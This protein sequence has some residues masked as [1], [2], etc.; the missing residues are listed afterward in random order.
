MPRNNRTR[1]QSEANQMGGGWVFDTNLDHIMLTT[2]PDY[3]MNMYKPAGMIVVN[4]V[5]NISLG[6]GVIAE[7]PGIFGGKNSL[8]QIAID[9]LTQNAMK[10]LRKKARAQYKKISAIINVHFNITTIARA[11]M[12]YGEYMIATATG[13]VLVPINED[14]KSLTKK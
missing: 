2:T 6:R 10:E 12:A 3:D 11:G 1:R 14:V 8:I 4:R 9:T 5:E 13:T 7:V